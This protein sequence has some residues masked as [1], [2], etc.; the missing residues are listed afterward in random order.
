MGNRSST[1]FE[2]SKPSEPGEWVKKGT[3]GY[4]DIIANVRTGVVAEQ[5][6]VPIDRRLSAQE[7]LLTYEFRRTQNDNLVRVYQV[8][9]ESSSYMCQGEQYQKV[10][11]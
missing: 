3:T 6:T 2:V 8:E 11:T 4:S 9:R 10:R 7:D 1:A 5:Y